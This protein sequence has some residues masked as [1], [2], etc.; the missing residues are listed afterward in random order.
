[1]KKLKI[2]C[3]LLVTIALFV[4]CNCDKNNCSGNKCEKP[5]KDRIIGKESTSFSGARFLIIEIDG[6][7]YVSNYNS[8]GICPLVKGNN[9]VK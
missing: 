9:E 3:V 2:F 5:S 6:V 8:G 1:M 7:E 4:S